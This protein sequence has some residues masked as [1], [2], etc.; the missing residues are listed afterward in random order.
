MKIACHQ[1]YYMPWAGYFHKM[2]AVDKF[3]VLDDVQYIRRAYFNRARI[4]TQGERKWITVPVNFRNRA[5][6]SEVQTVGR[7]WFGKHAKT[8]RQSY[9]KAPYARAVLDLIDSVEMNVQTWRLPISL[10]DATMY[11]IDALR[12]RLMIRTPVMFSSMIDY[13]PAAKGERIVNICK[14]LHADVYV[15]GSGAS[16]DYIDPEEFHRVGIRVEWQSFKAEHYGQFGVSEFV[17]G[18]S[19]IDM[20]AN[21]G[22]AGAAEYVRRCGTVKEKI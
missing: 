14:E 8:I 4:L 15:A 1:P 19:V 11:M 18:L 21:V 5:K 6:I 13:E 16:R 22:T 17:P 7:Q 3:V 9:A 2:S 20:I 12:R 10:S